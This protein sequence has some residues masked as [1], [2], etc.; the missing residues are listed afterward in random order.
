MTMFLLLF[1]NCH[2]FGVVVEN[3]QFFNLWALGWVIR[4]DLCVE[5]LCEKGKFLRA[6]FKKISIL[7]LLYRIRIKFGIF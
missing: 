6:F 4:P 1:E 5:F 3:Y 2:L 7:L